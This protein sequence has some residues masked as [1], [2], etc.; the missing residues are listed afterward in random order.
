MTFEGLFHPKL[1]CDS[2]SFYCCSS[3]PCSQKPLL[4]SHNSPV[5]AFKTRTILKEKTETSTHSFCSKSKRTRVGY[6]D[7]HR[8]LGALVWSLQRQ[9]KGG[10]PC[11]TARTEGGQMLW[12]SPPWA[13]DGKSGLHEISS[14]PVLTS[15]SADETSLGDPLCFID[16]IVPDTILT[17]CLIHLK[18]VPNVKLPV[19]RLFFS[20][21][22]QNWY[23]FPD[24]STKLP[25][26]RSC[27]FSPWMLMQGWIR[28]LE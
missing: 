18:F 7:R 25:F 2:C 10:F 15:V 4:S 27:G 21:E 6:E 12:L 19:R 1:F 22:F 26:L 23:L 8:P 20:P 16:L 13:L 3:F 17:G 24:A 5:G 28:W 9:Q 11:V 14:L